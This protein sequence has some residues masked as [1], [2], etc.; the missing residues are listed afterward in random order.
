MKQLAILTFISV[1]ILIGCQKD[2]QT[3]DLNIKS[4]ASLDGDEVEAPRL[5]QIYED[6]LRAG[7][8]V[9]NNDYVISFLNPR[10][11]QETLRDLEVEVRVHERLLSSEDFYLCV[12]EYLPGYEEAPEEVVSGG[13]TEL[14]KTLV[15]VTIFRDNDEPL[16]IIHNDAAGN[17]H[18]YWNIGYDYMAVPY[19]AKRGI[20]YADGRERYFIARYR[21]CPSIQ[22]ELFN[23]YVEVAEQEL[24]EQEE[25]SASEG[26]VT[27]PGQS[28]GFLEYV[29]TE[30]D[31]LRAYDSAEDVERDERS[32]IA[33]DGIPRGTQVVRVQGSDSEPFEAER[34]GVRYIRVQVQP[35]PENDETDNIEGQRFWVGEDFIKQ[36]EDCATVQ[37]RVVSVCSNTAESYYSNDEQIMRDRSSGSLIPFSMIYRRYGEFYSKKIVLDNNGNEVVYV[38]VSEE[39]ASNDI[40]WIRESALPERCSLNPEVPTNYRST[41]GRTCTVFAN[42][43]F[44]LQHAARY[45]YYESP[46]SFGAGRAGGRRHAATDLYSYYRGQSGSNNRYGGR[47]EGINR[48]EVTGI[49][50][51]RHTHYMTVVSRVSVNIS[52]LYGEIADLTKR[53]GHAI[54]RGEDIA[55]TEKLI[56]GNSSYPAMLHL[57]RY[58]TQLQNLNSYSGGGAY[59]RS[60]HLENPTCYVE[61]M[62][63]RKFDKVWEGE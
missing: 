46:A 29:C 11:S 49:G 31:P 47:V 52:W 3:H 61:Y 43:N 33:E 35:D 21:D 34:N 38:P 17:R 16:E 30:D 22:E 13:G 54:R 5:E 62:S 26:G 51:W 20:I 40:L 36:F 63:K 28:S 39:L 7:T 6:E 56:L 27:L 19:W 58:S 59:R 42:D 2:I 45:N 57:E 24:E 25:E 41:R 48:S 60:R 1:L 10:L 4:L 23:E 8:A 37:T 44:P 53:Q 18:I 50:T 14:P 32:E 15:P 55:K 9:M 12:N